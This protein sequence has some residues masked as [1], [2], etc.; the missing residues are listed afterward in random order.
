MPAR[1][2]VCIVDDNLEQAEATS[3]LLVRQGFEMEVF[4]SG[5][6]FLTVND[7]PETAC[8][9]LDNHLPGGM[10]GL[11]VQTELTR[12]ARHCQSCS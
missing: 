11:D 6:Q 3:K 5:E 12:R 7:Y 1:C 9:L 10:S 4:E 2:I 8:L